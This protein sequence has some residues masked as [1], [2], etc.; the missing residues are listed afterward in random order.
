MNLKNRASRGGLPP[1]VCFAASS[2][3]HLEEILGLRRLRTAC[4]H[5]YLTEDVQEVGI[6]AGERVYLLPQ[7]RRS[8]K[9]IAFL[10]LRSF[11]RTIKCFWIERPDLVISTGA[12]AT[13]PALLLGHAF[14]AKVVYIESQA[15]MSSLSLTG[16]LAHRLADIFFVQWEQLLDDVPGAVYRGMLS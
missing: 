14:G 8:D 16:K 2:G 9:H 5:F 6:A 4:P 7:M 3:G 15:R 1:K 12:L 13:V 10:A 11:T